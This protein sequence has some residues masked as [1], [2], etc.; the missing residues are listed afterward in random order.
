MTNYGPRRAR[1]T[2][3]NHAAIR[4]GLRDAFGTD[5]VQDVSM[6]AG[7]GFDLIACVRGRVTFLEV[8]PPRKA[9]RL[10]DSEVSARLRYGERWRVVATLDEAL[11]AV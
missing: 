3:D 1:R 7:L 5:A 2:D 10:T 6:Y 4:D 8:K 9:A 11:E